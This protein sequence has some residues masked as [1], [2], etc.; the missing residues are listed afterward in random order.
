MIRTCN[1]CNSK[2]KKVILKTII[3]EETDDPWDEY[4]DRC[5]QCGAE[6]CWDGGFMLSPGWAIKEIQK[7]RNGGV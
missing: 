6:Y 1:I 7:L 2:V 5:S 3:S 4:I